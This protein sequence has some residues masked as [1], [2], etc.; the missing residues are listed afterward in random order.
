[1]S[2][3]LTNSSLSYA[4]NM[5]TIVYRDGVLAGD[6]L[7]TSKDTKQPGGFVKVRKNSHGWLFGGAGSVGDLVRFF[8]WA[9]TYT[10]DKR[11]KGPPGGEYDGMIISP[12]GDYHEVNKGSVWT[13]EAPFAATGSGMDAA[14]GALHCGKSA[15]E[16]VE[17]ACLVDTC[18]GEGVN[19]VEID[20][21]ADAIT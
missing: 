20:R 5:T 15:V 8:D 4:S 6:R 18:S 17:I 16:A 13:L 14:L 9:E 1:M 11:K 10:G 12:H 2:T 21:K 3:P 7:I 19:F